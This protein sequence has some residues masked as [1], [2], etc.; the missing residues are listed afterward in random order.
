MTNKT[1]IDVKARAM[2][3]TSAKSPILEAVHETAL[4][5]RRLGFI[6]RRKIAKF[7]ALCLEPALPAAKA[8]ESARTQGT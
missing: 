3:E 5:L 7:D 6:G 2:A 4:D 1:K 8:A